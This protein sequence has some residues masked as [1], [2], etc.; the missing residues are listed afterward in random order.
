MMFVFLW[1]FLKLHKN[2]VDFKDEGKYEQKYP[3]KEAEIFIN[4]RICHYV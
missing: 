1:L 3:R 2:S 4:K